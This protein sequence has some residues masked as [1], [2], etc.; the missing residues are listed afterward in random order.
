[1]TDDDTGDTGKIYGD[2]YCG[3]TGRAKDLFDKLGVEYEYI[4]LRAPDA[5]TTKAELKQQ[6]QHYTQPWIFLDG[7]FIGGYSDL[8]EL[9]IQIQREQSKES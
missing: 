7:E 3:W 2:A 6:T 1:M 8:V 5:P 4:D 9:I